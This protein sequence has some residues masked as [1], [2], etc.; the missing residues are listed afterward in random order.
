MIHKYTSARCVKFVVLGNV[1]IWGI[2]VDIDIGGK[3]NKD[4]GRTSRAATGL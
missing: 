4:G 2:D 1:R 3:S